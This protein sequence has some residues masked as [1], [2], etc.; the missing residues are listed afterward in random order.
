MK[1]WKR[2]YGCQPIFLT[3]DV[4]FIATTMLTPAWIHRNKPVVLEIDVNGLALEP[5]KFYAHSFICK[6]NIPPS[7]IGELNV[8]LIS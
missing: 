3:D 5:D 8:A 4:Q 1:Q 7:Q 2:L 6:T